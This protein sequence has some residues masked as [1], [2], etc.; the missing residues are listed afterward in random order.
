M[1]VSNNKKKITLTII[2]VA[3]LVVLV[4]SAI[5][6]YFRATTS[7]SGTTKVIASAEEV[8]SIALTNPTP[9]LHLNL[10][11]SDMAQDNLGVYYATDDENKSYD[12]E[13]IA[14]LSE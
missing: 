4:L 13:A 1:E 2:S 5:L 12:E 9:E 8:G 3:T 7:S 10:S 6:A 14:A 11:V